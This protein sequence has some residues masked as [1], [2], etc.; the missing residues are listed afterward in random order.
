MRPHPSARLC[1][2]QGMA[3]TSE[4]TCVLGANVGLHL[5]FLHGDKVAGRAADGKHPL[6]LVHMERHVAYKLN[7]ELG[8]KSTYVATKAGKGRGRE[9]RDR[10]LNV[11]CSGTQWA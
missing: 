3:G 1:G 9:E 7:V 5:C 4:V 2:V 8:F 10:P 11:C 6:L